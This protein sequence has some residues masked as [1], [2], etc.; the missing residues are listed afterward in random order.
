MKISD[1]LL[2]NNEYYSHYDSMVT[3]CHGL[4]N[5]SSNTLVVGGEGR[6]K[7]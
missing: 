3:S 7:K 5:M 6:V 4:K 1:L 2:E